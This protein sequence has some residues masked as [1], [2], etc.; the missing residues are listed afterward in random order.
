MKADTLIKAGAIGAV[1]AA[2]CCATPALVI[3]LGVVGLSALTGYLDYVLVPA[4][5]LCLGVIGYGLYM[6]RQ[7]Q[8]AQHQSDVADKPAPRT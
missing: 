2:V 8:S 5:V 1:V 4:L 3:A 6:R 7:H